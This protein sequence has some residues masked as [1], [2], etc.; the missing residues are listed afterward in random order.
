MKE[1]KTRWE[2]AQEYEKSWWSNKVP[3]IDLEFYERFASDVISLLKPFVSITKNTYVLE[4]GSGAAGII[5]YIESNHKY[6]IDPLENY[7]S[8]ILKYTSIRDSKV[9]YSTGMAEKLPYKETYFDLIIMDNVLDHCEN[10]DQVLLEMHRV[11]KSEGIV[12]FRQNT[13]HLWGKL[14]REL[15]ELL[16][17]DKGHP[18]TFIKDSLKKKLYKNNFQILDYKRTGY[19]KTWRKEIGSKNIIDKLKGVLFVNRDKTTYI[20]KRT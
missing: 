8:T 7:Y 6:A 1:N 15:M 14:I 11:L 16:K 5:T 12:F 9:K 17:I 3:E 20:L 2:L 4:I 18:H 10:P 19:F 13:Y